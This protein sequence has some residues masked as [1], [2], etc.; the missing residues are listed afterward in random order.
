[1]GFAL[2]EA[3]CTALGIELKRIGV[4][5]HDIGQTHL[6]IKARGHRPDPNG[7]DDRIA[8]VARCFEF[9]QPVMQRFRISGSLSASHACCWVTVSC[10]LPCMSIL[11]LS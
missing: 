5:H 1:M 10:L 9:S 3:C 8:V 2:A 11:I 4:R 6:A 7:D